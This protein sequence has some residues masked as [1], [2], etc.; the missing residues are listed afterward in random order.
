MEI[1]DLFKIVDNYFS[2]LLKFVV[3][4]LKIPKLKTSLVPH[5]Y[6][7]KYEGGG[8]LKTSLVPHVYLL[9]YEGGGRLKTLYTSTPS[10]MLVSTVSAGVSSFFSLSTKRR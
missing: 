1:C 10:A 7:L 5:V 6:L 2:F 8:R 4:Q 3:L 9:K